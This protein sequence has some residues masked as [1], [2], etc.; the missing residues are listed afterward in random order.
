LLQSFLEGEGHRVV[1]AGSGPIALDLMARGAIRPDLVLTDFNLPDAM[2]GLRL[3]Q[4]LR[5]LFGA[6]LPV[7]VLTGDISAGSI[8]NVAAQNCTQLSKPVQL[9][10]LTD[11]I[12]AMLPPSCADGPHG[13]GADS[14]EGDA[15]VV[16]VVDGDPVV[17]EAIKALLTHD[18]RKSRIYA[19]GA[20]FLDEFRV[21]PRQC[22]LIDG[23]MPDI[24]GLE[25]LRRLRAAGRTIPT[26][27][28]TVNSDVRMAVAAMQAGASDFIE[29]PIGGAELLACLQRA[30]D[31]VADSS[32]LSAWQAEAASRI[33]RLTSRQREI[34]TMVLDGHPSK[35]IAADLHISQ[36][37]VENHRA[38]I[39]HKTKSSSM[40][41]LARLALAAAGATN[42]PARAVQGDVVSE[43]ADD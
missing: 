36:R 6:A 18:G 26:V 7:I 32:K 25:L 24:D 28:M 15:D 13:T 5:E 34:M 37:T 40:P 17:G 12:Q 11:L 8:V 23:T 41:A 39:M 16:F 20:A 9:H 14:E 31:S 30:V 43:A 3:A 22:L 4:R 2:N 35:N 42:A 10:E 33:G 21:A 27:I 38:A 1:A 29:K 19:S